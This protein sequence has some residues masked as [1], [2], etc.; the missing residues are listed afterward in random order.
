MLLKQKWFRSLF[1]RRILI[2][3]LLIL[4][5]AFLLYALVSGSRLSQGIHAVLTL[6]SILAVLFIVSRQDKG[7]YKVLWIFLIL[8]F[9]IFGGFLYLLVHTQTPTR[10]MRQAIDAAREKAMPLYRLPGDGYAAAAHQL[11][12]RLPQIRYLQNCAGFPVYSGTRVTY[13]PLGEA[14]LPTLLTQLEQAEKYIFLEYFI[15]QEGK[16]WNQILEVLQRKARQGVKVRVIYDDFG[17]FFLLPADYAKKLRQMGIECAVFNPFRPLLTFKQNN[18]DHRKIIS[19]D[20]KVAFT[21][22]INLA[23]E[24][25][26]AIDK[27]GHWKDTAVMLE[28]KA[29]WSL[30]LMFLEMWQVAT[31]LDEDFAQYYTPTAIPDS[32]FVLPWCDSPMD[33]ENVG[34]QVYLQ[35]LGEARDYVYINT[36][37]LVIDDSMVSALCLAAKRGV[38]VRLTLPH[39]GDNRAVHMTT[40]SY[41]PE[42]I[43]AGVKVYEYTPGFVHAKSFVCDDR[44]ATV[45]TTNLDFRSLYLNFECGV[46][47]C[48][49]EAVLSVKQDYLDTLEK[50]RLITPDDCRFG[51]L[52]KLCQNVMRLLAPLI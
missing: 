45:G 12:G 35:L 7:A 29:A 2:A 37:Y 9:P 13:F 15:I 26:N 14:M 36:P 18:R 49:C 8:S 44:V 52:R 4:Q 19:I 50:C 34:E 23:D 28:G 6:L 11:P 22:G 51:P 20:G 33:R 48:G 40:R 31:G 47:L 38:D 3:L 46:Y 42:L 43:T 5:L 21:G 25:I 10:R 30:T 41:Y 17:C 1:R 16:M 32:G 24:Y 27:Y 39:R